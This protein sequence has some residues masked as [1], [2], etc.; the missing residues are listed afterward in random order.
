[1]IKNTKKK[2]KAKVKSISQLRKEADKLASEVVRKRDGRCIQQISVNRRR[3][4]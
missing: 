1:M 3:R 4:L 2:A